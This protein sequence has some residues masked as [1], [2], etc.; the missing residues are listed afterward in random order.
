MCV[1]NSSK[2]LSTFPANKVLDNFEP[3]PAV[4]WST[5]IFEFTVVNIRKSGYKFDGGCS[6]AVRSVVTLPITSVTT[7]H[8]SGS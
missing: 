1:E 2:I 5:V 8:W 6:S 7:H 4:R 3:E